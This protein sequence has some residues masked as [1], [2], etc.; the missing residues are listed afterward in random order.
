[1]GR[2]S[3]TWDEAVIECTDGRTTGWSRGASWRVSPS[4]ASLRVYV[5]AWL[6]AVLVLFHCKHW[7]IAVWWHGLEVARIIYQAGIIL[8]LQVPDCPGSASAPFSLCPEE[9]AILLQ[10]VCHCC[11]CEQGTH[12]T[13]GKVWKDRLDMWKKS[14]NQKTCFFVRTIHEQHVEIHSIPF[15][16]SFVFKQKLFSLFSHFPKEISSEMLRPF[17]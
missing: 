14:E 1:M 6:L 8:A 13:Q 11:L 4:M 12:Y 15:V 17:P 3:G 5:R 10:V 2:S 16:S 9:E 7:R